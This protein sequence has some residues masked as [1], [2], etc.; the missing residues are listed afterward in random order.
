M[1]HRNFIHAGDH[2]L[3]NIE[4]NYGGTV[5]EDIL[6]EI[7][8]ELKRRSF[9]KVLASLKAKVYHGI[10]SGMALFGGG[11]KRLIL[12]EFGS[13]KEPLRRVRLFLKEKEKDERYGEFPFS[14]I[15]SK[16]GC[17]EAQGI[18]LL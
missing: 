13:T 3:C 4:L 16:E 11:G 8:A 9:Y 1:K 15:P 7:L 2:G 12:T 14:K 17:H 10:G 5:H 18:I 6:R